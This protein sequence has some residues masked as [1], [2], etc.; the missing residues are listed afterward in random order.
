MSFPANE[1]DVLETARLW[2]AAGHRVALA[3]VVKTKGS[4]PR[5][6]GSHIAVRDDG[7]F[8]GSVSAGC[9]EGSIIEES[10]GAMADGKHRTL[11]FGVS[12]DGVL[13][14]GLLCGGEIEIF[15]E[16]IL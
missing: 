7:L 11:T 16:P 4:A 1:S 3:T 8:A 10:L 6:N 9:V 15:V 2:L 12:D 5:Q 14:S 13:S